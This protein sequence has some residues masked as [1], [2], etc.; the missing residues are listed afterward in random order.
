MLCFNLFTGKSVLL[1]SRSQK[2]A[3]AK[4]TEESAELPECKTGKPCKCL[5][6][7]Y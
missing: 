7:V 2:R 3:C 6:V 4:V 5:A 1:S